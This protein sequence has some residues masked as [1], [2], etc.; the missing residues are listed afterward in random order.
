MILDDEPI[1]KRSTL[2]ARLK[3]KLSICSANKSAQT[4]LP[5]DTDRVS[6]LDG[7]EQK[8]PNRLR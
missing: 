7:P 5:S 1:F 4:D 6:T 3:E 2:E 8:V